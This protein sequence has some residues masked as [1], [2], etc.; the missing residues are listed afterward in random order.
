MTEQEHYNDFSCTRYN[1]AGTKD[2]FLFGF[3]AYGYA[4]IIKNGGK[5][6]IEERYGAYLNETNPKIP[7]CDLTLGVSR[8][9]LPRKDST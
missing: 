1:F 7:D 5:Q 4:D 3:S 8:A 9:Q 2:C 6:Y